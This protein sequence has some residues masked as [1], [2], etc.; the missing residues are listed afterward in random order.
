VF[1][2]WSL[3]ATLCSA[4]NCPWLGPAYHV[5]VIAR[6]AAPLQAARAAGFRLIATAARAPHDLHARRLP[7][8]VVIMLGSETHGLAPEL[9]ALADES[10]RIPGTGKLDSLNVACACSVLLS[11]Y[12][13][14]HHAA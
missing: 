12:W 1:L 13:R 7:G 10:V 9:A 6:S 14:S 8:R 4:Q 5:P 2:V 3:A 11:E